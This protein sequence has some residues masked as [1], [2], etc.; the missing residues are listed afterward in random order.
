[1]LATAR[2]VGRAFFL[3]M[4]LVVLWKVT[5]DPEWVPLSIWDRIPI[6]LLFTVVGIDIG[7]KIGHYTE[8]ES[9]P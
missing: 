7:T 9:G 2:R 1:M 6:Y 3:G 5:V 8:R 4:T